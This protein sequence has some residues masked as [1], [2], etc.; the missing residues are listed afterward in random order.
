[1]EPETPAA[2]EAPTELEPDPA[3][4]P[5]RVPLALCD[6]PLLPDPEAATCPVDV[7]TEPAAL[8]PLAPVA[9]T[10]PADVESEPAA[11]AP[12]APT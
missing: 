1:M 4:E 8:A 11:L 7:D 5:A 2:V 9:P 12:V 3:A 10:C 6:A